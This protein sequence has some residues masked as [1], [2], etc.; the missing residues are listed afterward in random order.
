[1][2]KAQDTDGY[3]S[4]AVGSKTLVGGGRLPVA[5]VAACAWH[6]RQLCRGI[7]GNFRVASVAA[8]PWHQWQDCYG[9]SG[10]FG[11]EYAHW[12]HSV[13]LAFP[14]AAVGSA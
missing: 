1:L 4:V 13:I 2:R 6:R 9:I 8:V 11:V 12:E 10:S 3:V 14:V 7:S 5:S